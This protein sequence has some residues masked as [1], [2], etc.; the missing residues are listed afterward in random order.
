MQL[1]DVRMYA[2]KE[3][4][5][6][7]TTTRSRSTAPTSR[8]SLGGARDGEALEQR[9]RTFV[10]SAAAGRV[11]GARHQHRRLVE[12]AHQH[13]RHRLHRQRA[14]LPRLDRRRQARFDQAEAVG[15]P[16]SP[17]SDPSRAPRVRRAGRSDAAPARRT[18]RGRPR[19]PPSSPASGECRLGAEDDP[20]HPFGRFRLELLVGGFEQARLAAEVVVERAAGDPG[21]ADDLLG[22]DRV[23]AARGE[24]PA[25]GGDQRG[26]RRLGPLRLRAT[27]DAR[28]LGILDV[29]YLLH[30]YCMYVS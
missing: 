21:G 16:R 26:P 22:A 15:R 10:T 17:A 28:D 19:R 18:R 12:G 2:Q 20:R 27:L 23:V 24:E 25:G 13:V 30:P 8:C 6:S 29:L 1:A 3:S 14:D 5:R 4:R 9:K 7:P 11:V